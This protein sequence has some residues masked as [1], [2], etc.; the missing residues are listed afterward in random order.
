MLVCH[1]GMSCM[2]IEKNFSAGVDSEGS[3]FRGF[4][5]HI[6]VSKISGLGFP[7]WDG[8]LTKFGHTYN[9]Y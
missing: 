6:L 8:Q 1:F 7:N 3:K 4:R 5:I 2:L 9:F